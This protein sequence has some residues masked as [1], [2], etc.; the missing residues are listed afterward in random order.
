MARPSKLWS[1]T[2]APNVTWHTL[3]SSRPAS[4]KSVPSPR[5]SL[6]SHTPKFPAASPLPSYLRTR[7]E[8]LLTSSPCRLST[9]TS[10]SP[11]LKSPP[12]VAR[13]GKLRL[14]NRT[15][16]S[17]SLEA[18]AKTPS[19]SRLLALEATLSL[20]RV[21]ASLLEPRRPPMATSLLD[22]KMPMHL[23]GRPASV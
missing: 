21:S 1:L 8:P 5:A 17:K 2:N 9:P 7:R 15:T 22:W 19:M 20:S 12:T 13:A 4:R 16:S 3:T 10:P 14:V 11:S 6:T 23:F 18:V